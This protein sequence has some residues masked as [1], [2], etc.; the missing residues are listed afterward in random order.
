MPKNIVLIIGAGASTDLHPQ[1]A[2]G[3][4]LV[5]QIS[6][7]VTDRTS[8][9]EKAFISKLLEKIGMSAEVR[10][11]F[12]QA[13]DEYRT[14]VDYASI[15]EFLDEITNYK[16]FDSCKEDYLKIA[17]F[18]I[19]AHIL[20]YEN[21]VLKPNTGGIKSDAWI[22]LLNDY[23]DKKDLLNP[24]FNEYSLKIITFNYDRNLEHFIYTDPRFC[25][26]KEEVKEFIKDSIV[27]VYG[28]IGDLEWQNEEDHFLYGEGNDNWDKMYNNRE[29]ITIMFPN[30]MNENLNA[31]IAREWMHAENVE[32]V[33]AFGFGFDYLN[34]NILTL[35]FSIRKANGIKTKLFANVF[36]KTGD[37]FKFRRDMAKKIRN[38]QHDAEIS[39][40]TCSE[41]LKKALI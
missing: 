4:G 9:S 29:A 32:A 5:Q 24:V 10:S 25:N 13:I 21:E 16:E 31:K 20:G 27:H 33:F 38:V 22:Y 23:I 11:S 35:D 8:T 40:L 18:A 15:D 28:K 39:Y 1:F 12:V 14:G 36:P 34:C 2:L 30:R 37:K 26:R 3:D 19:V 7:R 17:Q 41:F 6:D